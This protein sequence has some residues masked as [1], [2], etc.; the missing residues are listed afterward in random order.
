MKRDLYVL[1]VLTVGVP[2]GLPEYIEP[3][4]RAGMCRMSLQ[5]QS[6]GLW[7]VYMTDDEA[8]QIMEVCSTTLWLHHGYHSVRPE[9]QTI[10][11]HIIGFW[12]GGVK[13]RHKQTIRWLLN[14]GQ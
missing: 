1:I 6:S 14:V 13:P 5:P 3:M 2:N 9:K 12:T 8:S 7:T 11:T 4:T 10:K